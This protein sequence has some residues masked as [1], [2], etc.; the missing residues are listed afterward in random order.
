M[1]GSHTPEPMARISLTLNGKAV[2]AEVPARKTLLDAIREEWHQTGTHAGCEHGVCGCCNVLLDGNVVRSCLLLAVQADGHA[3]QTVEG[4]GSPERLGPL[5]RAFAEKHAMQCGYCTPGMLMAAADLLATN[6]DPDESEIRTALS[7]NLCRCTGYMEIV[8]AVKDAAGRIARGETAVE[9]PPSVPDDGSGGPYIGRRIP[10][11]EDRRF[12]AGKGTYINDFTLPDLLHM[13]MVRSP[14]AHARILNIDTSRAEALPGVEAVIVGTMLPDVIDPVP[15][16]LDIP[17]V[18]WYPLA[19]DKVR[20]AGEWVAAVVAENRYIAEDAAELVEVEYEPLEPVVDPEEA[21]LPEAPVLHEK[22]GSNIAY[23]RVLTYG[24]VDEALDQAA[25]V[26]EERYRWNRHSGVPLETFGAVARWDAARQEMNLWASHQTPNI[27]EQLARVLRLSLNQLRV[28]QHLDVGGSHGV[29]R[30]RKHM[31]LTAAVSRMLDRPVKFIEDRLENMSSGDGHGPDRVYYLRAGCNGDGIIQALDIRCIDDA[32]AY[33]G[34]GAMQLIKPITAIVGPY[35]IPAVRYHAISAL[36][37]K[38]NQ[39]PYRGFGQAPAG[40]VLERMVDLMARE[41]DIDR[42]EIRSR[43]FIQPDEF[44]YTIPTGAEYDSGDYPTC[45]EKALTVSRADTWEQRRQEAR[46]RGKW[47]GF[48]LS[49]VIEPG[50]GTGM[51]FA[52]MGP[53][54]VNMDTNMEGIRVHVDVT[55]MIT[56]T[57]GFQSC[58]QGH[59]T[60]T[61]QL[62]CDFFGV[63]PDRVRIARADSMEGIV[64]RATSGNRLHLMLPLALFSAGRK[65]TDKM[66]A[67]AGNALKVPAERVDYADG[68]FTDREDP[69]KTVSWDQVCFYA[70]RRDTLLSPGMEPG[71]MASAVAKHPRGFVPPTPDGRVAGGFATYTFSVHVPVVEVDSETLEIKLVDYYV[72]HDCGKAINPLMVESFCYGGVNLGIGGA[73]YEQFKYDEDGQL[74]T[75]TFMDY[76]LPST[77]EVPKIVL[78]EHETPAPGN[79]VGAKAAGESGY[80]PAPPAIISAVEDALRHTNV[81]ITDT[82]VTPD[83]LFGLING[84]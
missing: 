76:L 70:Y 1:S 8:D 22:H 82:P 10:P 77:M 34:R 39:S 41:L 16:N 56:V 24:P 4:L 52:V 13:T 69:E 50:G 18:I 79:P 67:I 12:V 6:P 25:H 60:T 71:L 48:G 83:I 81:R 57:I 80:M 29:K 63:S 73:L 43:N 65:I 74:L 2:E 3:V 17:N 58:G 14:H 20:Y 72:V 5:Q 37:S 64:T 49:T 59:E 9:E 28:H 38:T 26:F 21:I 40:Y 35:R 15:Q 53:Q 27:E 54:M 30:G 68:V 23:E 11:V 78:E 46:E 62:A 84:G 31:F 7:G 44:P 32:G 19:L 61:T 42:A 33:A 36:T 66:Q 75:Q 45:L 55:G 47:L 51:V